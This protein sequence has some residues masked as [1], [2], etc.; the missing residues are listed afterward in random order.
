MSE[1]TQTERDARDL[2]FREKVPGL[3]AASFAMASV[4]WNDCW[5]AAKDYYTHETIRQLTEDLNAAHASLLAYM[6][7]GERE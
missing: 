1:L 7:S 2:A 5:E 3:D 4:A 6:G